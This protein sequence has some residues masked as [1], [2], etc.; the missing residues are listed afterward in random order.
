[1]AEKEIKLKGTLSHPPLEV[2]KNELKVLKKKDLSLARIGPPC[3]LRHRD[4][5]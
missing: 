3:F 1:M 4:K 2:H 5:D